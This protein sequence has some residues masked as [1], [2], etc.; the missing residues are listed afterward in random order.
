MKKKFL[1]I[2]GFICIITVG[3]LE[4]CK[5]G[6]NKK[7]IVND[8][9]PTTIVHIN[10]NT[11]VRVSFISDDTYTISR[12]V[13]YLNNKTGQ[14]IQTFINE[15]TSSDI[16]FKDAVK[17]GAF[18]GISVIKSTSNTILSTQTVKNNTVIKTELTKSLQLDMLAPDPCSFSG[19]HSCV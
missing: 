6:D 12:K 13:E 15:I 2:F 14:I 10:Q 7:A 8:G 16:P 5:K 9:F 3:Y 1:F 11:D 4:S 17:R 19:I 18:N